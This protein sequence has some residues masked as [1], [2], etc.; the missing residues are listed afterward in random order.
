MG[1]REQWQYPRNVAGKVLGWRSNGKG[2]ENK[3]WADPSA[4]QDADSNLDTLSSGTTTLGATGLALLEDET[5]ADA[6][7]TLGGSATGI[8]VFESATKETALA[9]L[10]ETVDLTVNIPTDYPTLQDAIDA[11]SMRPVKQGATIILMIET[12]HALTAGVLVENGDFGHFVISAVDATVS[13]DAAFPAVD[14]IKGVNARMPQLNCLID[15][16][17]LGTNGY[18]ADQGSIG[19]VHAS[20]G[21]YRA[22]Q[23]ACYAN[24]GSTIFADNSL[25]KEASQAAPAYS[26]ILAWA[27]RISALGADVSGSLYYGAQAAASG[28]LHF[29]N[30]IA[31]GAARHGVRATNCA[32]VNARGA[33]SDNCGV[34]GFRAFD[35]GIIHATDSTATGSLGNAYQAENNSVIT[36][37]SVTCDAVTSA[38]VALG[39]SRIKATNA[40][41]TSGS[42]RADDGSVVALENPTIT[43]TG[44]RALSA[45]YGAKI[46]I[47]GG[48]VSGGDGDRLINILDNS[49]V[50]CTG[51]NL[52]A[53][54][55]ET[56]M[57]VVDNGSSLSI[58]G[59]THSYPNAAVNCLDGSLI[60]LHGSGIPAADVTGLAN[61]T[62]AARG[63]LWG[64]A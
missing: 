19:F 34:T 53:S 4:K 50:L 32:L 13:L 56:S 51:T 15:A 63:I 41:S 64:G 2:L 43:N 46:V 25:F 62:L 55:T 6:Q 21:I 5:K 29:R 59:G 45:V 10:G 8:S 36:A 9:A 60:R 30:G 28:T 48:S 22:A 14:I 20:C 12:G 1:D 61:A 11:L 27:S 49:E 16:N 24:A 3:D 44:A 33:S 39:N 57:A 26:G 35:S 38:F 23:Q 54:S 40:V 52:T 37:D 42:V 18:F 31:D 7:A 17:G 58:I 47:R